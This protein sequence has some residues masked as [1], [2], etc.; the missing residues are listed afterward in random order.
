MIVLLL[1]VGCALMENYPDEAFDAKYSE[2]VIVTGLRLLN[3]VTTIDYVAV[4][5]YRCFDRLL[6]SFTLD[7]VYREEC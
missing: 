7:K 1:E 6:L 3:T 2:I 5:I 4:A